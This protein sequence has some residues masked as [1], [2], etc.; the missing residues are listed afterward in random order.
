MNRIVITV[1]GG[2]VQDIVCDKDANIILLD[3]DNIREG[4]FSDIDI[5]SPYGIRVGGKKVDKELKDAEKEI[6]RIKIINT[7]EQSI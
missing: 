4:D 1:R 2:V 5:T 6:D 7:Q 3:W